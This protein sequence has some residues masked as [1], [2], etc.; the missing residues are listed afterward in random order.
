MTEE[1]IN[2]VS[3][4]INNRFFLIPRRKAI[5]WLGGFMGALAA[6]FGLGWATLRAPEIQAFITR[7]RANAEE[8]DRLVTNLRTASD[9]WSTAPQRLS[10]LETGDFT[11]IDG[12]H[13]VLS[14][15]TAERV[16]HRVEL[17][18]EAKDARQILVRFWI[19]SGSVAWTGDDYLT[20]SVIGSKNKELKFPFYLRP[21][22]Q[23]A[24]SYYSQ[25]LWIPAPSDLNIYTQL[26]KPVLT[27]SG[28]GID[29]I[30]WR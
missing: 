27:N 12:P 24:I 9:A 18:K 30:G 6:I 7:V 25:F 4:A 10:A 20:L 8:S 16:A 1:E 14:L 5:Y 22:P 26:E 15:S 13:L 23:G 21:Y 28:S 11:P 19:Y 3:E 29:V 2:K 17:P